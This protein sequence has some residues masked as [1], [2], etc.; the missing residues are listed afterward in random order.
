MDT[1][2][3]LALEELT[4]APGGVGSIVRMMGDLTIYCQAYKMQSRTQ[5]FI[6]TNLAETK[7][8]KEPGY[9]LGGQHFW[10]VNIFWGKHFLGS[11]IFLG[12]TFLGGQI[13]L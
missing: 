6:Q 10:G 3:R 5:D 11:K 13:I 8:N 9:F 1:N 2:H 12:S 7:C 4:C